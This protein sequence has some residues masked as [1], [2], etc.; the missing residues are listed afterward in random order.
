M[1]RHTDGEKYAE[2]RIQNSGRSVLDAVQKNAGHFTADE[3]YAYVIRGIQHISRGTVY[4]NL[5][6]LIG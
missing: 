4:R 1:M 6:L 3:I 5:Q 2:R